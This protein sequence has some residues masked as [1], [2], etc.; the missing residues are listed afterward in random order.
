MGREVKSR[1]GRVVAQLKIV[2]MIWLQ[3]KTL[4][5]SLSIGSAAILIAVLSVGVVW[6]LCTFLPVALRWLWVVIVPSIFAYS[7]YR[8]PVWLG[9]DASE[10]SAWAVLLVGAWFIAGAVPSAGLVLILRERRAR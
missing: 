8:L 4:V 7:L 1:K 3:M 9:D 10:Y 5:E 6:L 2:G